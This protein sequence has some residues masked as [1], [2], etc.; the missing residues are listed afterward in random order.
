MTHA[1]LCPTLDL[2]KTES[3]RVRHLNTSGTPVT[4]LHFTGS[5]PFGIDWSDTCGCR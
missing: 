1:P 4:Q 5:D 2:I 3:E